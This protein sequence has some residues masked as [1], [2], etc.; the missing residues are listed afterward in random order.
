MDVSSTT[1]YRYLEKKKTKQPVF[2]LDHGSLHAHL[3]PGTSD[4]FWHFHI[5]GTAE[6]M[7]QHY[8]LRSLIPS[9][10]KPKSSLTFFNKITG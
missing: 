6:A 8:S 9:K 2:R 3:T 5:G 10:Y 1:I 4:W 7:K